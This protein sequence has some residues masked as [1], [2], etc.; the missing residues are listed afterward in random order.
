MPFPL[1]PLPWNASLP[2][3]YLRHLSCPE[4]CCALAGRTDAYPCNDRSR[5]GQARMMLP[6]GLPSWTACRLRHSWQRSRCSM[7]SSV[8]G[9]RCWPAS[10]SSL[11]NR[12]CLQSSS[13]AS[14]CCRN[15]TALPAVVMHQRVRA[16]PGNKPKSWALTSYKSAP[17]RD[18]VALHSVAHSFA[19]LAQDR[20]GAF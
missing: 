9:A 19:S 3:A 10:T 5:S 13:S 12:P 4:H 1:P 7:Q 11:R 20:R 16:S 8:G 14:G 15:V 6:P 17:G 2:I 18:T